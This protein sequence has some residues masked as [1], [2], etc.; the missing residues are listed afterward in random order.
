MRFNIL[1][2]PNGQIAR[3]DLKLPARSTFKTRCDINPLNLV[4]DD[5]ARRLE[6]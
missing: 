4:K 1:P 5:S 3:N 2:P 6:W